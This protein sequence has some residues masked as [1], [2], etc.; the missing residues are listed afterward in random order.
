MTDGPDPD[1]MAQFPDPPEPTVLPIDVV[2]V[3]QTPE[4][5]EAEV[6]THHSGE[7]YLATYRFR[8]SD[9][10]ARLNRVETPDGVYRV[11][12]NAEGRD[13]VRE[14]VAGLPFVDEVVMF[15]G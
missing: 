6:R 7:S 1:A 4:R 9:G 3:D 11:K 12:E 2:Y 10:L 15:D 8:I 5:A 14:E 13:A